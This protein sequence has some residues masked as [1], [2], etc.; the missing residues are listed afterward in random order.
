VERVIR[1]KTPVSMLDTLEEKEINLS[2]K[3]Q[4]NGIRSIMCVPLISRSKVMGFFMW[5]L[6]RNLMASARRILPSSRREQPAA[7]AIE[8]SVLSSKYGRMS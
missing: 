4:V 6:S 7:L 3:H 8:N 1:E 2:E 5:T